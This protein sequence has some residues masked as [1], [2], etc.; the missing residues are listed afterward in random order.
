MTAV[1]S[2]NRDEWPWQTL[3][4][5]GERKDDWP[6]QHAWLAEKLEAFHKAF[7]KRVKELDA[8]EYQP[9]DEPEPEE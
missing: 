8:D 1:V 3:T 6:K 2:S 5:C 7:S 4:A 9:D